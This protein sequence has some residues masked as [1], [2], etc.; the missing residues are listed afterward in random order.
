MI[1]DICLEK[2]EQVCN[3]YFK[4]ALKDSGLRSFSFS[5]Q[6]KVKVLQSFEDVDGV[7]EPVAIIIYRSLGSELVEI[8]FIATRAEF[9]R[10]G[11]AGK[12]LRSLKAS[13]LW[14]ELKEDNLSALSF[15]KKKGFVQVGRREKYYK[16][17]AAA[18]N[19]VKKHQ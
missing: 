1:E 5:D 8:D 10:A 4:E 16:D 3:S 12:L 19:M 11:A 15:Y 17:G 14:L 13:E 7:S 6:S 2:A 9:K 18:L